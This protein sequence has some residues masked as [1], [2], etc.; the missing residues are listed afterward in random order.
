[1]ADTR[2]TVVTNDPLIDGLLGDVAWASGISYSF[3]S[4]TMQYGPYARSVPF[5]PDGSSP[6]SPTVITVN[7]ANGVQVLG[8]DVLTPG[9]QKFAVRTAFDEIA[10]F[11]ELGITFKFALPANADVRLAMTTSPMPYGT[12][13]DPVGSQWTAYAFYP[14]QVWGGDVWLNTAS[15]NTPVPGTYAWQT[16]FHEIGHALGLKHGHETDGP[17]AAPVPYAWDSLEFTVMT[18]RSYVGALTTGYVVAQGSYPQTYMALDI[19]TLQTMYGADYTWRSG[20]TTYSFSTTTGEMFV[21]GLGQ[22]VP[23]YVDGNGVAQNSNVIF[24]TVWDGG[25]NDTYDFSNY[26]ADRQLSIDLRAGQWSDVDTQEGSSPGIDSHFQAAYLGGG[27]NGGYARGQVFNTFLVGGNTGNLIENAIGGSGD[28]TLFGNEVGNRL[29]GRDGDDILQ[30]LAGSDVLVGG[31][32]HD[33]FRDSAANLQGDWITDFSAD[34]FIDVMGWRFFGASYAEPSGVL[35]FDTDGNGSFETAIQLQASLDGAFRIQASPLDQA[36]STR[37][38]YVPDTDDDGYADDVDN[39]V[40]VL[41]PDQRDSD[42]DG[43]GNI[44]DADLDNTLMVDLLDL[45]L[46]ESV[47]GTTGGAADF[48]GDDAVDLLDLS[49]LDGLFGRP[50]GPS[51]GTGGAGVSALATAFP[52]YSVLDID[53]PLSAGA[54]DD[55]L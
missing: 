40:F 15:Y 6:Q 22:G 17:A 44:V 42:G 54:A 33:T 13:R 28:D 52:E 31:A 18:Y 43:Y 45:A 50:P 27:P 8:G 5:D 4:A 47:F 38:W 24:R 25:G 30:G 11:S 10:S 2:N 37:L 7:E 12:I 14:G 39:A 48:N 1:M 34:D 46:F 3:P 21:N 51:A 9:T 36:A 26:G 19:L 23:Q 35:S 55:L 53:T 29:E 20:D 32:G 49:V 41:N 16:F